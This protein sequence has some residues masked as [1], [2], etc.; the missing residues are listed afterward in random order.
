MFVR[1]HGVLRTQ[2][3]N[4]LPLGAVHCWV[5]RPFA[6]GTAAKENTPTPGA[7][8]APG[9]PGPTGTPGQFPC[10]SREQTAA[11]EHKEIMRIKGFEISYNEWQ[12]EK[13][14]HFPRRKISA[15]V[16]KSSF[17]VKLYQFNE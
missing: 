5:S 14:I 16:F 13:K 9:P 8:E 4:G 3:I 1:K 17:K 10:G 7:Q 2:V 11:L 12:N 15:L 6:P